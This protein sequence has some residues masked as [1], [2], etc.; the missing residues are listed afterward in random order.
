MGIPKGE[1]VYQVQHEKFILSFYADELVD[2]DT[3]RRAAEDRLRGAYRLRH[4]D[5]PATLAADI[6]RIA[7]TVL[8]DRQ[9]G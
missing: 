9:I 8:R 1:L 7:K 4:I 6:D 2:A 3:V 5:P